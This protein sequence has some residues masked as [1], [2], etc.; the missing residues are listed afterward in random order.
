MP[1][2]Q[3][4]APPPPS[5]PPQNLTAPSKRAATKASPGPAPPASGRLFHVR[6][7]AAARPI[8]AAR[9]GCIQALGAGPQTCRR[10][11]RASPLRDRSH[12]HAGYAAPS[13]RA[14]AGCS[15]GG[16]EAG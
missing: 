16:R 10:P 7:M 1:A 4:T 15:R 5:P 6:E 14:L 12:S 2:I 11:Q 3:G 9:R 13:T 8:S